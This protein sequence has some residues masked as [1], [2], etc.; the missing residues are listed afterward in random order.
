MHAHHCTSCILGST[1]GS[2]GGQLEKFYRGVN[3]VTWVHCTGGS[4]GFSKET[5]HNGGPLGPHFDIRSVDFGS[6]WS[7]GLVR[8]IMRTIARTIVRTI[9]H[10]LAHICRLLS[11]TK[12]GLGQV[13]TINN[14]TYIPLHALV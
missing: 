4:I 12:T 7:H 3:W 14:Q 8:T 1:G 6:N 11:M 13:W 9:V 5:G 10:N 2:I